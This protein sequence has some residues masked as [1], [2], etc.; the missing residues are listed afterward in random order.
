MGDVERRVDKIERLLGTVL[1][2]DGEMPMVV[3]VWPEDETPE[4]RRQNRKAR[5]WVAVHGWPW[6]IDM[7][8]PDGSKVAVPWM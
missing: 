5:A 2:G 7:L 3:V 8:W 1:P 6:P 4:T